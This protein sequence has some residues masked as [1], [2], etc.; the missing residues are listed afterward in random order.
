MACRAW[1]SHGAAGSTAAV[2]CL[3][4][5]AFASVNNATKH[6]SLLVKCS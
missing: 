2:I 1:A 5:S 4:C 3:T 6:S